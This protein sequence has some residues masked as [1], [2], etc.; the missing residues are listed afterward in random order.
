MQCEPNTVNSLPT[1][2]RRVLAPV[3]LPVL[4]AW[5]R[6]ESGVAYFPRARAILEDP[7]PL[8]KRMRET[9]P[10]HR[11][12]LME[13]WV[14]TRY[15][16]VDQVLR[17]HV[18]FSSAIQQK[19][20][21]PEGAGTV[22]LLN[23]DPPEHTRLRSLV[24]EAFTHSSVH[25]LRPRIESIAE[26]LLD[27]V[28][29]RERFE[30]VSSFAH[31]LPVMVMAEMLGVPKEDTERF[32]AWSNDVIASVDPFLTKEEERRAG[33]ARQ[34]LVEYFGQMLEVRRR[35]PTDDIISA[36]LAARETGDR[37]SPE[38]LRGTLNLLLVAGNETTKNLIGNGMLAL[39]QHPDQMQR[40]RGEPEMMGAAVQE[41][42]R[43]DPPVQI[44]SRTAVRDVELGGRRIRGGTKVLTL[45]GAANRDPDVFAEPDRMDI[46]RE[47]KPHLAFGRGI[48]YC[49]G[50]A[51]AELE[52]E[53][54]FRAIL[55]R[56][57]SIRLASEPV[58]GVN[59]VLRG[60]KELWVEVA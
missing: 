50:A 15:K 57:P 32:E 11:M 38:E 58:R 35:E 28:A 34:A 22:S 55:D 19:V 46:G 45:I 47:R 2:I 26:R 20:A 14:V 44:D 36:L 60:A 23:L 9:D 13:A 7:Y 18:R 17:D 10:V 40:L 56:F 53:I 24:S 54:A 51:L 4:L 52:A 3:L 59:T 27:R 37:L 49:L 6:F 25:R 33:R 39:L 8:Y 21:I 16:H 43:Y 31:P 41:F 42:L 29:G 12:R 1:T 5:E 30:L 48:H